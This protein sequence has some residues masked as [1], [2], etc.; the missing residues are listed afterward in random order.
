MGTKIR[1]RPVLMT[2][3]VASLGFLPMALSNGAGAEVQRPLATVVIG[4]L[5]IATFLT[6][7]VLPILYAIFEGTARNEKIPLVRSGAILILV[8]MA[9]T[10]SGYSQTPISLKAAID[11]ALINNQTVKNER[12]KAEYQRQ[13]IKSAA[14]IPQP[15][16]TGQFGQVNSIYSD[17]LLGVTQEFSFPTVYANQKSLL[18]EEWKSSVL[19]T[20][21][22][23]VELRKQVTQVYYTLLFLSEKLALLQQNDSLYAEF[24]EKASLRYA[25]GET[26]VLEKTTAEVQRGQIA[27]Q[28]N[29]LNLD[30]T[31]L[32]SQF[33]LLLNAKRQYIPYP[34]NL[35]MDQVPI[36]DTLKSLQHPFLALLK[37]REFETYLLTKLEKS[38][39]LPNMSLAYYNMSM[40]GNGAD[41]KMYGTALGFQSVQVGLSVPIFFS[42]QAARVSA[43][44]VNQLISANQYELEQQLMSKQK[45]MTVQ[46]V[47]NFAKQVTYYES[48]ALKNAET[49]IATANQQFR[50]GDINYLEWVMLINQAITIRS[51]YLDVVHKLNRSTIDLNYYSNSN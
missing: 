5:L 9:A 39:Q 29:L 46:Q 45:A 10:K 51:D 44:K 38:R 7:F 48:T 22:R 35:K 25:A 12:L 24:L 23:E 3:F 50:T 4:G 30:Y 32:L 18:R 40:R 21:V 2:A 47:S 28:L 15:M 26:S 20:A 37:Q 41:N 19:S 27:I 13:L 31:L 34:V 42:A 1:L 49:I 43:A 33:D 11:T 16:I 17:K 6:L 14:N 36:P 8:V